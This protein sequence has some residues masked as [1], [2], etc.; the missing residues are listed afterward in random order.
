MSTNSRTQT[1]FAKAWYTAEEITEMFRVSN[2]IEDIDDMVETQ[3]HVQFFQDTLHRPVNIKLMLDFHKQLGY[4][5][6]GVEPG[7][8]R[9]YPVSIGGNQAIDS[10][11]IT[12]KIEDLFE[13]KPTST[14]QIIEWHKQFEHIHPFGDGNGRTGRFLFYR[15][16]Y[17][18]KLVVPDC[19]R[20]HNQM[21]FHWWLH[22]YYDWFKDSPQVLLDKFIA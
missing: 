20:R 1:K 16:S 9:T 18:R 13:T 11:Q 15:Q 17:D 12:E 8:Y 4:L 21:G 19:I 22:Q 14:G 5:N 7:R 10:H 2:A 3:R 6:S